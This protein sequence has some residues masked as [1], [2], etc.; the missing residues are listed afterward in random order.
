MASSDYN[1]NKIEQLYAINSEKL[2]LGCINKW[3]GSTN[4]NYGT[5]PLDIKIDKTEPIH[6]VQFLFHL[7]E[8]S[9]MTDRWILFSR[10]GLI[11]IMKKQEHTYLDDT[12]WWGKSFTK[13]FNTQVDFFIKMFCDV[14][15]YY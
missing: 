7:K 3:F 9:Y 12:R 11:S 10:S 15:G 14:V 1:H 6:F 5:K 4:I 13:E 2:R 8:L